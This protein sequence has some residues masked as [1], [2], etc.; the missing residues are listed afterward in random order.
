MR[1][2]PKSVREVPKSIRKVLKS[3]RKVPN[4]VRKDLK[5]ARKVPNSVRKVQ[6]SVADLMTSLREVPKSERETY[7]S[8][9]DTYQSEMEPPHDSCQVSILRPVSTIPDAECS[10]MKAQASGTDRWRRGNGAEWKRRELRES[11]FLPAA[12]C[13]FASAGSRSSKGRSLTR[14]LAPSRKRLSV[15]QIG[16]GC[17]TSKP[18]ATVLVCKL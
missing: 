4:S 16:G 7:R 1:E 18:F 2:V 3:E 13:D 10:G 6:T 14:V 17:R 9:R 5:S 15:F 11:G 8:V 12:V